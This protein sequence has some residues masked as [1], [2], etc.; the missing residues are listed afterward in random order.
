[1]RYRS[2]SLLSAALLLSASVLAAPPMSKNEYGT[3]KAMLS[4]KYQT[5]KAACSALK[6]NAEDVCVE[7]AK[8]SE[9]IAK[10][11]LVDCGAVTGSGRVVDPAP[12]GQRLAQR[13]LG[14]ER[15]AF[16][17][18]GHGAATDNL[19]SIRG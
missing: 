1:M 2:L 3:T 13:Y 8:A 15:G 9:K 11:E 10:A 12:E 4:T 18:Q 7:E 17:Q 6:G 16:V 14:F 5:D 19:A